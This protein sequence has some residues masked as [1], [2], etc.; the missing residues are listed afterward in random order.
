MLEEGILEETAIMTSNRF[1]ELHS[2]P[3]SALKKLQRETAKLHSRFQLR[4]Q[5]PV[6]RQIILGITRI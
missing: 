1:L 2:S 4:A 5:L 6:K 3:K